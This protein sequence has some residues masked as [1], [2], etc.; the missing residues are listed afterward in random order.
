MRTELVSDALKQA[1]G[2]RD[3]SPDLIFHSDWG[4]QYGS[5]AYRQVL[6]QAGMRQSI[7]ARAN[8]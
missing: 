1:L 8:P 5:A 6:S 2:S 4:S 7:S 3:V